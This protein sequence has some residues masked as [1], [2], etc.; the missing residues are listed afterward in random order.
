MQKLKARL[1]FLMLAVLAT[2]AL[3]VYAQVQPNVQLDQ[4]PQIN[5][6][7]GAPTVSITNTTVTGSTPALVKWSVQK[8][9]LTFITRFD[10]SVEATFSNGTRLG[11]SKSVSDANARDAL[12]TLNLIQKGTEEKASL[13]STK[14]IIN[15]IF[16]TPG[17]ITETEDFTLGVTAPPP[18]RPQPLDITQVSRLLSSSNASQDSFEVKWSASTNFASLQSFNSFNVKLDVTYS[19]GT[20]VSGSANAS[21]AERQ[22][23]IAVPKPPSGS[24]Q[25]VRATINAAV[26]LTGSTTVVKQTP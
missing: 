2:L 21:A 13:Q 5:P 11:G 8:P 16:T 7:L 14:T 19:D 24:P 18:L 26:T 1:S 10:I 20:T 4:T 17:N 22:K 15:T 23:I 12:I 6:L 9:T 3:P 25:T